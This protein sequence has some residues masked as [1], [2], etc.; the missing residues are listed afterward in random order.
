MDI[1]NETFNR[2]RKLLVE[3]EMEREIPSGF[4]FHVDDVS[5]PHEYRGKKI[6]TLLY[7]L[8]FTCMNHHTVG[9]LS[10]Y[11]SKLSTSSHVSKIYKALGGKVG[12]KGDNDTYD[13]VFNKSV[14]TLHLARSLV[15]GN[16]IY[17]RDGVCYQLREFNDRRITI[18]AFIDGSATGE[19]LADATRAGSIASTSF[20]WDSKKEEFDYSWN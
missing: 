8:T 9:M 7:M 1:F 11:S 10:T 16:I 12:I 15:V 6:G 18:D 3:R 20:Y 19:P 14:K 17:E 4:Y 5:V 13:V 2:H